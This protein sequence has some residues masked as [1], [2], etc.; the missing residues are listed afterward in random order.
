MAK[1]AYMYMSKDPVCVNTDADLKHIIAK[2]N[3]TKVSHLLVTNDQGQLVGVIS[4]NDLLEEFG[5]LLLQSSGKTYT[6]LELRS[7]TA[8]TI[9]TNEPL[10]VNNNASIDLAIE[11]LLQKSF[12]CVPVIND[13]K[14]VG[15]LTAY[16]LLKGYYQE[17]G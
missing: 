14:P 3:E 12:H 11:Y 6:D 15:I 16:D 1:H 13:G 5:A 9:M 10:V 8:T 7:K 2:F 17:Y 4:K